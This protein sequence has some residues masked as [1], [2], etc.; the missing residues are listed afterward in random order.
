MTEQRIY[1]VR[2][3]ALPIAAT[4]IATLLTWFLWPYIAPAAS[5]LFFLAVM[6]SA[7]YGGVVAGFIA[8]CLSAFSTAFFFMVPTLS[9]RIGPAD[10]FRLVVFA[11]VAAL[12]NS[13]AAERNRV[14]AEERRLFEELREANSRIR[15][16]TDMLPL[17]P[18]CK[19]VRVDGSEDG[20]KTVERYLAETP[21][22][23]ITHALCPECSAR[24]FPEFHAA[25][26]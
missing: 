5:P 6:I 14:Q 15:T 12:T 8:T 18:D 4:A 9:L 19:R 13:I 11:A 26:R 2:P 16:L 3:V 1:W 10:L 22:L 7:V 21:E 17:C 23:Q 25:D 24:H 20:W